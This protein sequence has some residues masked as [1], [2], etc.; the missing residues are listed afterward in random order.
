MEVFKERLLQTLC[1]IAF[2]ALL[3]GFIIG[4]IALLNL[5]SPAV[6]AIVLLTLFFGYLAFELCTF[7]NWLFVQP[8]RKGKTK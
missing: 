4:A 7:I 5:I 3:A 8:F 2:F 6:T 1:V